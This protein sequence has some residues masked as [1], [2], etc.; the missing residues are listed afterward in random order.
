MANKILKAF[1]YAGRGL[2]F[3]F[4]QERNMKIHA[5]AA[6]F[7]FAAVLYKGSGPLETAAVVF[8]VAL[9]F[10]AEMFNTALENLCNLV[11]GTENE[12]IGI[13]KDISA[14]AVLVSAVNALVTAWLIFFRG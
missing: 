1:Y 7:A 14:G 3:A 5:A 2:L 6:V 12:K 4:R 13:I 11:D 9:V 10:V 8:A